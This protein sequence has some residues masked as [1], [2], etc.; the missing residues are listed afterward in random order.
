MKFVGITIL[1]LT[2]LLATFNSFGQTQLN[3]L[4][5]LNYTDQIN[6]VWG[7]AAGGNEYAIVG[8][9]TG[10]SIVNVTNPTTPVETQF[11]N[12]VSTTWRDIKV[13]GT[14]AYVINEAQDGVMIIDLTNLPGTCTFNFWNGASS[15]YQYNGTQ[16]LH[17]DAH[18]IYIDEFGYGY[19]FGGNTPGGGSLIIDIAGN[20]TDPQIVGHYDLAYCHDGFV[21]N[22]IMYTAEIYNGWFALVDVSNKSSLSSAQILGTG[23]TTMS[24]THNVWPS[25]DGNYL[26]TTDERSG[27]EVGSFDISNPGNIQRLTGYKSN[28]GSGVV[29]H[30]THVLNDYLFTSYYSDGIT[31][32]CAQN[33]R[34]LTE[35]AYYDTSPANSG[36][37]FA[38]CWGAYPFL[39]SGKILATDR[40]N[41]LHVIDN[42]YG[43]SANIEGIVTDAQ[44]G[45]PIFNATVSF[46]PNIYNAATAIDGYYG[47]G[48]ASNNGTYTITVTAPGYNT[49]TT[50]VNLIDCQTVTENVALNA[51]CNLNVSIIGLPAS[52][53][54]SSAITLTASPAGGTFSGTG[55]IFNAFN[56]SIAG[57]GFHTITYNYTDGNGCTGNTTQDILVF[58]ISYNFVNYNLGTISP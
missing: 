48:T 31:V 28:P 26:F 44:T 7:Y 27:S 10:V 17:T 53:S 8:V 46:S 37:G 50:T 54:G 13:W 20:P 30:N 51:A 22:N 5:T 29:P 1:L 36:N 42:N 39:P 52:T 9:Q 40:Q 19:L 15:N 38:G 24:F 6:D 45:N 47:V 4:G 14:N 25:D 33:P 35:I 57:P 43:C 56:P 23:S 16:H 32:V 34:I 55:V 49:F 11:I 41:G 2:S 3:L 12:H 18:N 21:R 58:S